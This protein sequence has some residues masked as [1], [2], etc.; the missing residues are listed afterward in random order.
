MNGGLA[1]NSD[2]FISAAADSSAGGAF[3]NLMER[4]GPVMW[5][6][7]ICSLLVVAVVLERSI[8]FL[9]CAVAGW[10]G[11]SRIEALFDELNRGNIDMVIENGT[12]AGLVG[13]FLSEG[14]KLRKSGISEGLEEAGQ[15]ILERLRRGLPVL[16]TLVTLAPMLGILGTVTGII[17]SF[18]LMGTAEGVRGIE[19]ISSGIA[20]ALI[21]TAAGLVV[22][23]TALV[24]FNIF[25]NL[26]VRWSRKLERAARRCELACPKEDNGAA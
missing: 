16:D 11:R 14:L 2:F 18:Q 6:L 1:L 20:E 23:M 3:W 24:P 8:V 15:Q 9:S 12:R 4:G 5:P 13:H 25:K 19:A 17:N 21:T 7:L 22:S 26:H 10:C